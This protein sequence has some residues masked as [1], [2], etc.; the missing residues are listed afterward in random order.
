MTRLLDSEERLAL[1][2]L[3]TE[4]GPEAPTLLD[5]WT[6]RDLAAHLYLRAKEPLAGP[7]LV[8]P[9]PWAR[10]SENRRERASGMP[11]AALLDV[12]RAEP[13]GLFRLGWVRRVPNLNEWFVHHEDVRRANGGGR[14]DLDE[15]LNDA[16]WSNVAVGTW[17]LVRHVRGAGLL[18]RDSRTGR[19]H[20]LRRGEPEVTL[21]GEPGELVLHLFGRSCAEVELKGPAA[22]VATVAATPFG[23]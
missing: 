3:L 20:R 7:G 19:T 21:V 17:V 2:D 12:V 1:C 16:L 22:A 11:Y 4:L 14:R 9:G 6:T 18:A 10:Y 5:P 8:L 23:M 15:A 13:R